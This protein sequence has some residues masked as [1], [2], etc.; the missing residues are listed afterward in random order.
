MSSKDIHAIPGKIEMRL[1]YSPKVNSVNFARN[2]TKKSG[3]LFHRKDY[4]EDGSVS[5]FYGIELT[6]TEFLAMGGTELSV[7]PIPDTSNV[8]DNGS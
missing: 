8:R 6:K 4:H 7:I 5:D 1:G 2:I 3:W